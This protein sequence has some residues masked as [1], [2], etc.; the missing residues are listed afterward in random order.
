MLLLLTLN[1]EML[2]GKLKKELVQIVILN[3]LMSGGNKMS[4]VLK[5]T[6]SFS[7]Q[8]C[9]GTYDLLLPPCIKRLKIVKIMLFIVDDDKC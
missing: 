8:V 5:Q 1:K 7:L 4:Y 2:P 3:P 6:C 9:L